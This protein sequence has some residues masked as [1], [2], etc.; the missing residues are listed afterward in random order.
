MKKTIFLKGIVLV[1][2]FIIGV[3]CLKK[4][5]ANTEKL[6]EKQFFRFSN[7]GCT[8]VLWNFRPGFSD[9][10]YIVN[11]QQ[12]LENYISIDCVPQIDFSKYFMVIGQKSFTTG[13]SRVDEKLEENDNEIVYTITILTNITAIAQGVNYHAI[14]EKP[15]G[16]KN[17]RVELIIKDRV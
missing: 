15:A 8:N 7:F 6:I 2:L 12:E 4:K 17:I 1:L 3:A 5:E 14:I 16:Q 9:D 11:S 10:H 13:V